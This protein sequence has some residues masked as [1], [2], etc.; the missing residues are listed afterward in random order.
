MGRFYFFNKKGFFSFDN[1][2][3]TASFR[4][5]FGEA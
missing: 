5:G 2:A 3:K 1:A 4:G